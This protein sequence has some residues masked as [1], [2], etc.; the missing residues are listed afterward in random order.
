[1]QYLSQLQRD[2]LSFFF[3]ALV[4]ACTFLV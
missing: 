3:F 2:H 1:M 4:I